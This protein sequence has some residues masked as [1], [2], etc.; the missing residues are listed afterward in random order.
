MERKG[1]KC[2]AFAGGA[3]GASDAGSGGEVRFGSHD[4]IYAFPDRIRIFYFDPESVDW[5]GN[6]GISLCIALSDGVQEDIVD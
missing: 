2:S 1:I 4:D 5:R 3:F 6:Q